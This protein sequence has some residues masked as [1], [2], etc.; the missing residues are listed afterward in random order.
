MKITSIIV[1]DIWIQRQKLPKK[2]PPNSTNSP[3]F[4]TNKILPIE[5]PLSSSCGTSTQSRQLS[6]IDLNCDRN[7]KTYQQ[8]N[9]TRKTK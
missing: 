7:E 1:D 2:Q 8:K 6:S 5:P 4:S 3:C 9:Q